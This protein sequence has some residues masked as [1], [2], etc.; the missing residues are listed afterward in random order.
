MATNIY[1][2]PAT[3][4]SG[5]PGAGVWLIDC[6]T[7]CNTGAG[8]ITLTV[9]VAGFAVQGVT[10][11]TKKA[12]VTSLSLPVQ[13][14]TG[15]SEAVVITIQSDNAADTAVTLNTPAPYVASTPQTIDAGSAAFAQKMAKESLGV[16]GVV[17][18]ASALGSNGDTLSWAT[19]GTAVATVMSAATA[20]DLVKLGAETFA[21]G[22]GV[23][24]VTVAG[25]NVDGAGMDVTFITSTRVTPSNVLTLGANARLSNLTVVST[26]VGAD[27]VTPVYLVNNDT[28]DHVHAIGNTDGFYALLAGGFCVLD[29][30]EADSNYDAINVFGSGTLIVNRGHFRTIGPTT[31]GDNLARGLCTNDS[32]VAYVNAKLLLA[33][34]AGGNT[35]GA[36]ALDSS[37][38]IHGDGDIVATD[39]SNNAV[40]CLHAAGSATIIKFG[41]SLY[42][43]N[44][45]NTD[46]AVKN[47]GTGK[48]V[49]IGVDY[50]RTKTSNTSTGSIIDIPMHAVDA[51]G[52]A[53]A[54]ASLQPDIDT[55]SNVK[56]AKATVYGFMGTL[57]SGTAALIV[58]A[59]QKLFNI[60]APANTVNDLATAAQIPAHFS[61]VPMV[62][63]GSG[64][65]AVP[66]TDQAGAQLPA[67]TDVTNLNNLSALANIYPNGI[68]LVRPATSTVAYPFTLT[69]KDE[70]GHL[71]DAD[72]TPTLTL[73]NA[74]G[75]DRSAGL[76][77]VSHLATG[78]YTFTYTVAYTDTSPEGL[79]GHA[80]CAV[81]LSARRADF[82]MT[83][84][85]AESISTMADIKGQ[86]DKLQFITDGA[87][88]YWALSKVEDYLTGKVP[89]LTDDSRL[90]ATVIAAKSDLPVAP[91]NTTIGQIATRL[92]TPAG[93]GTVAAKT[94]LIATNAADSANAVTAQ[95]N[96]AT[97]A[98][99][100]TTAAGHN[101][102]LDATQTQAATAAAL[103]AFPAQK[104]DVAVTLPT[105]PSGYGITITDEQIDALI[106]GV[107]T[108]I[109][110]GVLLDPSGTGS[111]P[112]VLEVRRFGVPFTGVQVSVFNDEA[113]TDR[114]A[115][116]GIVTTNAAGKVLFNLNPDTYWAKKVF[117]GDTFKQNPQQITVT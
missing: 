22:G 76:S 79:A 50:D 42:S 77:G 10:S 85:D 9:T 115:G 54:V 94:D 82:G 110:I 57:L 101:N 84:A 109:D 83:V 61:A 114:V 18:H 70:E 73:T 48:I 28:C 29:D 91:D 37:V 36:S 19:A 53:L 90:P 65:Y 106:I 1:A 113:C 14:V 107:A 38:Q 51:N 2:G 33:R 12:G 63:L 66:A 13:V 17:R 43:Q 112:V 35:R 78:V 34:N 80:S 41:G 16:A 62:S 72:A 3:I 44:G 39:T 108:A 111:V 5:T 26:E 93:G 103:T 47:E 98:T 59:W 11:I 23:G 97:A 89:L 8:T 95:G 49:L 117:A 86:V 64:I 105:A 56:Y 6:R 96:A 69:V 75:T 7:T 46:L 99:A 31:Q 45:N 67:K 102:P 25:V 92:G 116:T 88:G 71:I 74:A 68:E 55:V 21:R 104:S 40:A 27:Y 15:A 24:V 100:A 87:G 58:A 60:A 52:L 20:G 32:I 4:Y 81:G 30:C